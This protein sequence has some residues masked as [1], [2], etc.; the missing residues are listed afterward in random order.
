V[1]P[2]EKLIQTNVLPN[3]MANQLKIKVDVQMKVSNVLVLP[4]MPLFVLP[5][6][7]L[8]TIAV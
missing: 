2:T 5:T 7:K 6:E 1:V 8:T 3:V 4:N